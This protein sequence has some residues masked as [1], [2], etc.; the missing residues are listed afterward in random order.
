MVNNSFFNRHLRVP[1]LRQVRTSSDVNIRK[2]YLIS[3]ESEYWPIKELFRDDLVRY[4]VV[5]VCIR[6]GERPAGECKLFM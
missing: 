4:P 5:G 3:N 1:V 6:T 2:M